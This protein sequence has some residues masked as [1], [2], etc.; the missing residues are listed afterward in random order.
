[1]LG[2]TYILEKNLKRSVYNRK[3]KINFGTL[4][5]GWFSAAPNDTSVNRAIRTNNPGAMNITSWQKKRRGYAG[6][7]DPDSSGNVT[8]VYQTPE[9]GVSAWYHLISDVYGFGEVGQFDI[10][11]IARKYAGS[12]APDAAVKTY[13]DGWSHWS[14]G[15]LKS[16]SIIHL[17]SNDELLRFAKALF[18]HEASAE[19]PLSDAQI[20]F[21][22]DSE[23]NSINTT[24]FEVLSLSGTEL[25]QLLGAARDSNSLE[26]VYE[27]SLA[28]HVIAFGED[29]LS[30]TSEEKLEIWLQIFS[31]ISDLSVEGPADIMYQVYVDHREI[32]SK[33]L[34]KTD[35]EVSSSIEDFISA[36]EID[37]LTFQ[38][39]KV[40]SVS[41]EA[42]GEKV[43]FASS[44]PL[45]AICKFTQENT[46]SRV[47]R[48]TGELI[49]QNTKGIEIGRY[50]VTTGGF[51][52]SYKRKNGP[53]PPGYFTVNHYRKRSEHWAKRGK[54]GFTF[55]LEELV[56]TGDRS[57]FRIHPDG[58]P[59]GTH[60]C[61]GVVEDG[62]EL[63]DCSQKLRSNL[64]EVQEFRLLVK[65]GDG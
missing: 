32:L 33:A 14:G 46:D 11:A 50:N 29:I 25:A 61:I 59:P 52:A 65:Y 21:G 3:L 1:M 56:H 18:A 10:T 54:I 37:G 13:I 20:V 41:A 28:P 62:A 36:L 42:A 31:I 63:A 16:N 39:M 2:D 5:D 45:L 26:E 19:T 23:R 55:D 38:Q 22:F 30:S 64:S 24:Q 51:V 34:K 58:S 6:Y 57:A 49:V 47:V 43:P 8:T 53:C 48:Y 12:T 40:A 44:S 35:P 17:Q 4:S 27:E 15:K 60:G 9:H 7:T